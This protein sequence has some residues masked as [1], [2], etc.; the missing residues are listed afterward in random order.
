ME[1]C[2]CVDGGMGLGDGFGGLRGEFRDG[3]WQRNANP[4]NLMLE[5]RKNP[6]G[7]IRS[8]GLAWLAVKRNETKRNETWEMALLGIT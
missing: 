2:V 8:D 4:G 6:G 5:N 7:G 3:V 1:V